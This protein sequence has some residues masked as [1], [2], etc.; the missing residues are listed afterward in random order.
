MSIKNI[1][2][3]SQSICDLHILKFKINSNPTIQIFDL[4]KFFSLE[5]C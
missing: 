4:N 1:K 3:K 5:V 2:N